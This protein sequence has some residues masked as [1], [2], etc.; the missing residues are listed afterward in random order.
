MP[1]LLFPSIFRTN[2]AGSLRGIEKRIPFPSMYRS[3]AAVMISGGYSYFAWALSFFWSSRISRLS[4]GAVS[5]RFSPRLV[6][7]E[8]GTSAP[9]S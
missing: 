9:F 1:C 4:S 3:F 7:K 2:S 8:V 5:S 6:T